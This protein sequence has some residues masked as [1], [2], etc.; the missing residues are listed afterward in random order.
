VGIY[1]LAGLTA[2]VP[3][4]KPARRQI[5]HKK[6]INTNK[7]NAEQTKQKQYGW[8]TGNRQGVLGQQF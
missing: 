8:K 5:K 6:G 1:Y 2:P 4:I 7:Q 3:I